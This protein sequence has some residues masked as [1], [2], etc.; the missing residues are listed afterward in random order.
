MPIV[1]FESLPDNSRVWVFASAKPVQG[2]GAKRLLAAADAFL[3]D[4]QAHGQPLTAGRNWSDNRFLTIAVDQTE[5][6][7]SGCSIDGLFR[8]LKKIEP[9]IGTT[10]LDRN[11][12][13]FRS[14]GDVNSVRRS[15]FGKLGAEGRVNR[16]TIVFDPSVTTLGEWRSRFQSAVADSWHNS[17]LIAKD[18]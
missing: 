9:E 5:S 14:N 1:P 6:Y 3:A 12:I 2:D 16:T 11:L 18:S 8:S 4:W 7:A 13:F 10:L 15:D 17:L